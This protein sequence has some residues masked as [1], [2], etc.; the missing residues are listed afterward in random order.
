[1]LLDAMLNQDGAMG[2]L[3]S[4]PVAQA[5]VLRWTTQ[6]TEIRPVGGKRT[7]LRVGLF[8][9]VRK[10]SCVLS[11]GGASEAHE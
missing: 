9:A 10:V 3:S 7:G 1:M 8:Q 6:V 4:K 2:L 11:P 5:E